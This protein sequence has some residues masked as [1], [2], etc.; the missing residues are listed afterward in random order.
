MKVAATICVDFLCSS[1]SQA[2]LVDDAM[3]NRLKGLSRG[4]RSVAQSRLNA[5]TLALRCVWSQT[6]EESKLWVWYSSPSELVS[7]GSP[8]PGRS[9]SQA[10]TR[11]AEQSLRRCGVY[12]L[13]QPGWAA[14]VEVKSSSSWQL[15]TDDNADSRA[16]GVT[17]EA[18][19]QEEFQN[20]ACGTFGWFP[21][22][23]QET[24]LLSVP[25]STD[26]HKDSGHF[27]GDEDFLQFRTEPKMTMDRKRNWAE[28]ETVLKTKIPKTKL[29]RNWQ[30]CSFGAEN[31]YENEI[32]SVSTLQPLIYRY[33]LHT[34]AFTVCTFTTLIWFN[35]LIQCA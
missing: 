25:Y 7:T 28:N 12:C 17:S 8:Q 1:C 5:A 20:P 23:Q 6:E 21:L 35:H 34:K 27:A 9:D 24:R 32:R 33:T 26:A 29:G 13:C 16:A 22:N 18:S 3:C 31:E 11:S 15:S 10:T 2:T 30:I 14:S 4:G 19:V